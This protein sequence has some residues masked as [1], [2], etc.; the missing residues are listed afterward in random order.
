MRE[1]LPFVFAGVLLDRGGRVR[2]AAVEAMRKVHPSKK[3]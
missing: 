1:R 2:A 3:L